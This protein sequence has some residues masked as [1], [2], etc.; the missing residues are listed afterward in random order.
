M[1]AFAGQAIAAT[2]SGPGEKKWLASVGLN[3]YTA[4]MFEVKETTPNG[5]FD[6]DSLF[7]PLTGDDIE[8]ISLSEDVRVRIATSPGHF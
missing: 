8:I 1:R 3:T 2:A 6:L 5:T 4:D 7:G